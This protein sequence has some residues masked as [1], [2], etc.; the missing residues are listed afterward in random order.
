MRSSRL[1]RFFF[2]PVYFENAQ[3]E[4]YYVYNLFINRK[5]LE[6][7]FVLYYFVV[8]FFFYSICAANSSEFPLLFFLSSPV[9]LSILTPPHTL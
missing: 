3:L 6:Y 8:A 9:G 1:Q 5:N 2:G 4:Y 7:F